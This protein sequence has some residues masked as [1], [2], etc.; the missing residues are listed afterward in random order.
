M[1]CPDCGQEVE[2]RNGSV[3]VPDKAKVFCFRC[4][5]Q[6]YIPLTDDQKKKWFGTLNNPFNERVGRDRK[7]NCR[8]CGAERGVGCDVRGH[9]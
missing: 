2:I 8:Q 5:E 9:W 3:F 4:N 1:N 7:G 6:K